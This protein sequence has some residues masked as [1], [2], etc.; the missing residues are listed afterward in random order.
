MKKNRFLIL[1]LCAIMALSMFPLA[2]SVQADELIAD[3]NIQVLNPAQQIPEALATVQ[4]D[5]AMTDSAK[6]QQVI[7]LLFDAKR[8]QYEAPLLNDF[9]FSI[10][11]IPENGNAD[12][13]TYFERSVKLQKETYAAL[14]AHAVN[15]RTELTFNE[16]NING[17]N[18]TV[19]VYEWFAY[20]YYS[21]S[22]GMK[23]YESGCGTPYTITMTKIGPAWMIT[24]IEFDNDA[25]DQLRDT[26]VSIEE[27]VDVAYEAATVYEPSVVLASSENTQVASSRAANLYT[28][29]TD[30]FVYYAKLYDGS[31]RNSYFEDLSDLG[32]DC[33]NFA[34]QCIW[35][36]F[37][38]TNTSTAI[39]ARSAPMVSSSVTS[40]DWR[41]WYCYKYG[42]SF[43]WTGVGYFADHVTGT[44][45]GNYGLHGTIYSGVAQ[46]RPG[47][48]IQISNDGGATWYH[49][50]VVVEVVGITGKRTTSDITISAHTT[51]RAMQVLGTIGFGSNTVFRTIRVTG[52]VCGS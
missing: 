25:T 44:G 10:F 16:L 2:N 28:F 30:R 15:A 5:T 27:L 26:D 46:A 11:W 7:T 50:Y 31:A 45:S 40:V 14:E 48:I 34:S 8:S 18:A 33:Q 35:Y 24:D 38:G 49:S 3:E 42:H 9:N 47:D 20:T 51:D 29:D 23:D 37:G 17:T 39:N 52:V 1:A 36:A 19:N 6:I 21:A 4:S 43:T 41:Q 13:L 32:G 22:T 12:N